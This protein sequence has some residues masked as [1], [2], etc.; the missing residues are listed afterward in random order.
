[1]I[2]LNQVDITFLL[3]FA[4]L[5]VIFISLILVRNKQQQTITAITLFEKE[6]LKNKELQTFNDDLLDWI[7]E[8][9]YDIEYLRENAQDYTLEVKDTLEFLNDVEKAPTFCEFPKHKP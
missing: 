4:N 5:I 2:N 6:C 7:N 3:I 1:M 8:V 9:E